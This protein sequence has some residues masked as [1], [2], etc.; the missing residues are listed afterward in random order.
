MTDSPAAHTRH[1]DAPDVQVEQVHPSVRTRDVVATAEY[2]VERLGFRHSFLWGEPP[3]MAGVM[4]GSVQVFIQQGDPVPDSGEIYFVI[5]DADELYDFH[6]ARGV[7]IA[8][9]IGNRNYELRDYTV[10]DPN[11]YHLSF[12][13]HRP[14]G[15]PKVPITRVDVPVRL[16]RRLAAVL[17]DLAR[18]KGMTVS[19]CLE[20]TLLHTFE[21]LGDGVAS[22]HTKAQL[23]RIQRFKATHGLDYDCHA[24]YRFREVDATG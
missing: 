16:E 11:G 13:H 24:S 3:T 5:G 7:P 10:R 8:T 12:G 14:A 2:Y 18:L 22:P 17:A 15:E 9:P 4:L 6:V 19:E 20:E 21:P 23:A 1:G